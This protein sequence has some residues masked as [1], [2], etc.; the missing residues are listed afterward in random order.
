MSAEPEFQSVLDHVIGERRC[1]LFL[2]DSFARAG[3]RPA[4]SFDDFVQSFVSKSV[5]KNYRRLNR[6]LA[7]LGEVSYELSDEFSDYKELA[8]Q[9]LEIES[10]GW[11]L[12]SGTALACHCSTNDFY[13]EL[14]SRSSQAG[15]ARFVALKLDGKPIAMISDIQ[16]GP[17]IFAFKTAFDEHFST[18]SPGVLVELKNIEYMHQSRIEMADSCTDPDNA[19][20]NRIWGQKLQFQSVV[21]G[22][23]PGMAQLATRLMP[24]IQ[25]TANKVKQF[26][27]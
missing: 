27:S 1:T 13:E 16:S 15:K 5:R 17:N 19:T 12:E 20:I 9:F 23:R 7:E 11:K 4:S 21:I 2:R 6:K 14:I 22:L 10:S 18:F 3:F 8:R 26:R 25:A 24:W